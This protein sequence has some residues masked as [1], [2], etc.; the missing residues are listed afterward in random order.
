MVSVCIEY[1]EVVCGMSAARLFGD[2]RECGERSE[3]GE[4]AN[5]VSVA[6]AFVGHIQVRVLIENDE[7]SPH[8]EGR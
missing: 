5:R 3:W 8:G 1:D 4:A 7:N 2:R 6:R